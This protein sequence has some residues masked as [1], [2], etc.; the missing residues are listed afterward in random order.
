MSDRYSRLYVL[1]GQLYT[2][3]APLIIV[4]GALLRDNRKGTVLGQLKFKSISDKSIKAL[5]VLVFPQD[6]TGKPLGTPVP[7]RYL[8]LDV[9]R[10]VEFGQKQPILLPDNTIRG[11]TVT[12]TQAVFS[13]G[14][15]WQNDD[16]KWEPLPGAVF[17]KDLFRDIELLKEYRFKYGMD[18]TCAPEQ[19]KD[20]WY[21]ACGAVNHKNEATCHKCKK[22]L[23]LL[24][25][26]DIEQ[27]RADKDARLKKE[28]KGRVLAAQKEAAR[29]K[30]WLKAGIISLAMLILIAGG[31]FAT[32][33]FFVP[34][35]KYYKAER[36]QEE[37]KYAEAIEAYKELGDFKDSPDKTNA[38]R[39]QMEYE[40]AL[41]LFEQQQYEKA[42]E[43]FSKLAYA[44]YEDSQERA[45]ECRKLLMEQ[46]NEEDYQNA[47]ELF[48][49][50]DYQ[51]AYTAFQK[52]GSYK[53]SS[54][55][56]S[57]MV[58][59]P[60][61]II[62]T[63]TTGPEEIFEF[64]YSEKG[65]MTSAFHTRGKLEYSYSFD[66]S[67]QVIHEV[68]PGSNSYAYTYKY[69]KK[70]GVVRIND[71]TGEKTYEYDKYGNITYQYSYGHKAAVEQQY[72]KYH[73]RKD[74]CSNTYEEECLITV[75]LR[76]GAQK[77]TSEIN[78]TWIYCPDQ[79][80]DYEKIWKNIRLISGRTV[81]FY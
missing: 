9:Q 49:Q 77:K 10:D 20:I 12:V 16:K 75:N 48:R 51:G 80:S 27:L 64:T 50:G 60:G 63:P 15:I 18:S 19:W 31:Y 81:W 42:E 43:A 17:L 78:Y 74:S 25:K 76:K 21:C 65:E 37:G 55:Y 46:Q 36:M 2:E 34:Y 45:D 30:R 53:D 72:D 73:N 24:M 54:E 5:D 44:G 62:C 67:G 11:F 40:A 3:S 69:G 38:A 7:Y 28:E 35:Y 70:G 61:Q 13:D 71:Y 33:R 22:S 23:E 32:V 1:P 8:D 58:C 26:A 79:T 56:L 41:Q 57:S 66:D 39:N 52:L 4:A 59:V 68:A 6:V 14:S 47:L 29:K